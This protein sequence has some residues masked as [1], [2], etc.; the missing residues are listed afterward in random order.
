MAK[1]VTSI[2]GHFREERPN[3]LS[4]RLFAPPADVARLQTRIE[5]LIRQHM[6]QAATDPAYPTKILDRVEAMRQSG[7]F[8]L[9]RYVGTADAVMTQTLADL[10]YLERTGVIGGEFNGLVFVPASGAAFKRAVSR[11]ARDDLAVTAPPDVIWDHFR[12]ACRR[13]H[14]LTPQAQREIAITMD[15][16]DVYDFGELLSHGSS[17]DG[18]IGDDAYNLLVSEAEADPPAMPSRAAPSSC[19]ASTGRGRRSAWRRCRCVSFGKSPTASNGRHTRARSPRCGLAGTKARQS[20]TPPPLICGARYRSALR[21]C[22]ASKASW[23]SRLK[24]RPARRRKVATA[25]ESSLGSK[26]CG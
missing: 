21:Y 10:G 18:Y 2:T 25:N 17:R 19:D 3:A 12:R 9:R 4:I 11:S 7:R 1:P 13:G 23:R 16:C 22:T 6:Q 20:A 26:C 5:V 8:R 15:D 24:Q 14:V